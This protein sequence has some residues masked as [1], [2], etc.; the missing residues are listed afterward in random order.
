[1]SEIC[2]D[3]SSFYIFVMITVAIILW[4]LWNIHYN[5]LQK[6]A[7]MITTERE[8]F[9]AENKQSLLD[10]E[11]YLKHMFAQQMA[12]DEQRFVNGERMMN[13]FVPPVRSDT[14]SFMGALKSQPVN[15]PTRGEYGPFQQFGYL[16]NSNDIEKAMPLMGRKVDSNRFEYY[17]F[18]HNNNAIKI[19]VNI[20]GDRE[21]NDG[22][23]VN[24]NGYSG[25]FTAKLYDLD[26]PRYI[27]Y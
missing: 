8:H 23:S 14:L 20:R 27:P 4:A 18:H 12:T 6:F 16:Q 9:I 2:F 19:P 22:D 25:Q 3:Q 10:Q 1:M 21:I 24:V 17:T 15:I 11:Q 5:Q 7:K 26:Y 13:P